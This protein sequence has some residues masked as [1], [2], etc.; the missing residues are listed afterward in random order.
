MRSYF[1]YKL[2]KKLFALDEVCDEDLVCTSMHID[3]CLNY[4][5]PISMHACI[6]TTLIHDMTTYTYELASY[7]HEYHTLWWNI[8]AM[9]HSYMTI[10]NMSCTLCINIVFSTCMHANNSMTWFFMT[11]HCTW[12]LAICMQIIP[13]YDFSLH[14]TIIV[15]M[16]NS[17]W[18]STCYMIL[19]PVFCVYVLYSYNTINGPTSHSA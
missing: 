10:K 11:A 5:I 8:E 2:F 12:I 15:C 6:F 19:L 16:H 4:W 1:N 13:W 17:I 3:A 9:K 7:S 18:S 14:I